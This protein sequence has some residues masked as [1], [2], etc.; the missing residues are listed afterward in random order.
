MI[1]AGWFLATSSSFG[2]GGTVVRPRSGTPSSPFRPRTLDACAWVAVFAPY[3]QCRR[4]SG[5]KEKLAT[6]RCQSGRQRGSLRSCRCVSAASFP[7]SHLPTFPPS[8]MVPRPLSNP[9]QKYRVSSGP[10]PKRTK[11]AKGA[12]TTSVEGGGTVTTTRGGD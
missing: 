9:R 7:P 1:P 5:M 4:W 10:Q 3:V 12:P 11:P 2:N 6:G 8:L